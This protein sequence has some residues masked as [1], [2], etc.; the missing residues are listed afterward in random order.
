MSDSG[1]SVSQKVFGLTTQ[2]DKLLAT[3]ALISTIALASL[4]FKTGGQMLGGKQT[5]LKQPSPQRVSTTLPKSPY[6]VEAA[7]RS[8]IR[9]VTSTAFFYLAYKDYQAAELRAGNL[10]GV[11]SSSWRW[12]AWVFCGA[13]GVVVQSLGPFPSVI[14]DRVYSPDIGIKGQVARLGKLT[15]TKGGILMATVPFCMSAWNSM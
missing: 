9:S 14:W 5:A 2:Q 10:E 13:V 11:K 1:V 3:T 7:S 12:K 4:D 15:M 8:S 6:L